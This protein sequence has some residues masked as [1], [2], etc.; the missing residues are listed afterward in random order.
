MESQNSQADQKTL[1]R[2]ALYLE[3]FTIVPILVERGFSRTPDT[4][5]V[6][7]Y[8]RGVFGGGSRKS[9]TGA[10]SSASTRQRR[11]PSGGIASSSS[12]RRT[13]AGLARFLDVPG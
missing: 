8:S 7:D 1:V 5:G 11:R 10:A 4:A 3:G 6:H 12:A 2:L 9:S 13:A